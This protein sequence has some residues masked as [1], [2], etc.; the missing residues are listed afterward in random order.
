MD[1]DIKHDKKSQRF[2][3]EIEKKESELKYKKINDETLDFFT[4][5]VPDEHRE[6]GIASE[7]TEFALRYA[8]NN[9]YKVIPS[10]PFV[11]SYID[12]HPEYQELVVKNAEEDDENRSSL[13]QYW[14]LLSLILVSMLAA[15]ALNWQDDGGMRAWMHYFMGVFLV[16]FSTLKIF[17]PFDFADGFEMYDIIAKRSRTYAYSYP[18]IELLLGLA[19]L[20]FFLPILTYLVTIVLLTIGSVGVVQALQRG[21]D[22]NCP[23]MGT[24]LDVP[25][26]TVTL[27]EDIGMAL[28]ALI[29]LVMAII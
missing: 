29:L 26:S 23:C 1:L 9:N 6:Q 19:F 25:L 22:I 20:S 18:V 21:L 12:D 7:I 15:F 4:T 13:K 11:K 8:K 14:P 3:V 16:I 24:V 5:F 28:M 10:C 17:H 27:T 2:V